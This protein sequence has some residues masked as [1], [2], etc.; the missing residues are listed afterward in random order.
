MNEGRGGWLGF[1][2][3]HEHRW[4]EGLCVDLGEYELVPRKAPRTE[5]NSCMTL[6]LSE[7]KEKNTSSDSKSFLVLISSLFLS[8]NQA[9]E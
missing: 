3:V 6:K 8:Y 5:A 7:V 9:Q 2:L 4:N 1:S